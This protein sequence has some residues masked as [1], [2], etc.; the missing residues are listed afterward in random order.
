MSRSWGDFF[1]DSSDVAFEFV[2]TRAAP[3]CH[4]YNHISRV[5]ALMLFVLIVTIKATLVMNVLTLQDVVF[6]NPRFIMA[7]TLSIHGVLP[8][9]NLL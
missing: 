4:E 1:D 6:V 2:S 7:L 9:S 3:E 8:F 5:N